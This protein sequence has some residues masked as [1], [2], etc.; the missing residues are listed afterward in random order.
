[1]P[2]VDDG[3]LALIQ[4]LDPN[5]MHSLAL[6]ERASSSI[7][8]EPRYMTRKNNGSDLPLCSDCLLQLRLIIVANGG[9]CGSKI[10]E[11]FTSPSPFTQRHVQRLID[12]GAIVVGTTN[13]DEFA[14][15]LFH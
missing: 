6:P 14:M 12:A 1:M 5:C 11:N 2:R 13:T 8:R 10:L 7:M 15:G 3:D 9:H 4:E